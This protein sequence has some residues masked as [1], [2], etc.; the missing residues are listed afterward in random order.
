[1]QG[2]RSN[3]VLRAA[4]VA[5]AMVVSTVAGS[6]QT[7]AAKQTKKPG[8]NDPVAIVRELY[9]GHFAHEQNWD[10][11][12]KHDRA[13]FAPELLELLD[14]LDQLQA[15][16][17]DEVVGLDFNP[18]T[19]AQDYATRYTVGA[20]KRDGPNAIVPVSVWLGTSKS[21]VR[22]LLVPSDGTWQI[23]NVLYDE[24]FDL[25]GIINESHE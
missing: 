18:L 8:A 15:A 16:T 1:M 17:P 13:K 19:N 20:V 6:A 24:G 23:M 10:Y 4:V 5:L 12:I 22:I 7:R 3:A 21:T 9:R 2:R 14:K 25:I 11:T